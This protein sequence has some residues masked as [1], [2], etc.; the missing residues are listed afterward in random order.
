MEG[1]ALLQLIRLLGLR[2][3]G[4]ED[5]PSGHFPLEVLC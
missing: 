1:A 5:Q 4:L 3:P 2:A